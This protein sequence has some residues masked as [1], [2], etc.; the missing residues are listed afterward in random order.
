MRQ[1]KDVDNMD[2]DVESKI[3]LCTTV[4]DMLKEVLIDDLD[5]SLIAS[6]DKK[7]K[8]TNLAFA[9]ENDSYD[10]RTHTITI[11]ENTTAQSIFDEVMKV[12]PGELI[13]TP[14][15]KE[16]SSTRDEEIYKCIDAIHCQLARIAKLLSGGK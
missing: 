4:C 14:S 2:R 11:E 10:I 8:E 15:C 6:V 1:R 5:A 13:K 16:P 12:V 7:T 9:L 3:K